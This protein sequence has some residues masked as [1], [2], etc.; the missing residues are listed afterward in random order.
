MCLVC[1]CVCWV[2]CIAICGYWGSNI[3]H[4]KQQ[5]PDKWPH[6]VCA[7]CYSYIGLNTAK[8]YISNALNATTE[9]WRDEF[10][11]IRL[12]KCASAL[13]SSALNAVRTNIALFGIFFLLYP[14][15]SAV[16]SLAEM[17][18]VL[19]G[20]VL[21]AWIEV[22]KQ[23]TRV[24]SEEG[25][26]EVNPPGKQHHTQENEFICANEKVVVRDMRC[27]CVRLNKFG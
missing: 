23:G 11:F 1:V 12:L 15:S 7:V 25:R 22:W 19:G 21:C 8:H 13:I 5:Q 17:D 6:T 3:G 27:V 24:T 9:R 16:G 2:N 10:F 4:S 20:N 18:S 14:F 26:E